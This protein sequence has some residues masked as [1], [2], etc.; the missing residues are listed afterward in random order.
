MNFFY[1]FFFF[2]FRN[3]SYKLITLRFHKKLKPKLLLP[4]CQVKYPEIKRRPQQD[5][6]EG[7]DCIVDLHI[8]LAHAEKQNVGV[9]EAGSPVKSAGL[10]ELL[11]LQWGTFCNL[12]FSLHYGS[13]AIKEQWRK[14]WWYL[15]KQGT[16]RSIGKVWTPPHTHTQVSCSPWPWLVTRLWIDLRSSHHPHMPSNLGSYCIFNYVCTSRFPPSVWH[17]VFIWFIWKLQLVYLPVVEPGN[18]HSSRAAQGRLPVTD[19]FFV[20]PEEFYFL[21]SHLY[22]VSF[23]LTNTPL[24]CILSQLYFGLT[25]W[26]W[27]LVVTLFDF[28][29]EAACDDFVEIS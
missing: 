23:H 2:F 14:N 8:F 15:H 22:N 5:L 10:Y 11:A 26:K 3:S 21:Y 7:D 13:N 18:F 25:P 12:Q 17:I 6:Q 20:C 27:A 24:A 16:F 4:F 28:F 1:V 29:W 19:I 9:F